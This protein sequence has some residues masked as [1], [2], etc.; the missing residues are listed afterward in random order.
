[1]DIYPAREEPIEDITS[2]TILNQTTN[3]KGQIMSKEEILEYLFKNQPEVLVT[4]GAG[5]IGL[6]ANEIETQL[7]MN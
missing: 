3:K 7:L 2:H 5:D 6:L 1:M 4:M